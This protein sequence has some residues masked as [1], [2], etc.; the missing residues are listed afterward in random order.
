MQ[1]QWKKLGFTGNRIEVD[2]GG[3]TWTLLD[4]DTKPHYEDP[5]SPAPG[6]TVLWKYRAIYP[7][8]DTVFGQWSDTGSIAATG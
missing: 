1:L 3:G 2:R 7:D 8:G 5:A 6:A 4:I